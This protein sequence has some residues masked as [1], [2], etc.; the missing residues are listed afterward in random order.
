MGLN[1]ECFPGAERTARSEPDVAGR[2]PGGVTRRVLLGN[3]SVAAVAVLAAGPFGALAEAAVRVTPGKPAFLTAE[4][5]ERL[6]ALVDVFIPGPPEDDV[7]GALEAG[8]AEAIDAL[9]GAFESDPPRI[10]AGAPFSD[11]HGSRVD[12]FK[13]FLSLDAYE[14]LAWRLRIQGSN[15]NPK[16]E[17]NGPVKGWQT[18]YRDGLAALGSTFADLPT[19]SRDAQLRASSDPAVTALVDVAWPHTYQFMYAAPEYGANKGLIGWRYTNWDGD[20]LPRGYTR[21]EVEEPG[22]PSS[23]APAPS[24]AELALKARALPL[25]PLAAAP[26]LGHNLALRSGHSLQALRRELAAI[27]GAGGEQH[28]R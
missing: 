27:D 28:G 10:Y 16:L 8:C 3:G 26:E 5:L 21:A 17:F 25:A 15:G 12:Y 22:A 23:A 9:L 1:R 7:G 2:G 6:R 20:M 13:H 19:A 18:I 11:R 24:S 4:Q 14:E